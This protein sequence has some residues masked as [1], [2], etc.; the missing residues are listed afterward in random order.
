MYTVDGLLLL[1]AETLL[2]RFPGSS[3]AVASDVTGAVPRAW[4]GGASVEP[5]ASTLGCAG[6]LDLA[7]PSFPRAS[8]RL[9]TQLIMQVFLLLLL[10]SA[11]WGTIVR[12]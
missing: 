3:C 11:F 6:R 9:D 2:A 4:G 10:A 8:E 12:F 1:A 7:L 5:T